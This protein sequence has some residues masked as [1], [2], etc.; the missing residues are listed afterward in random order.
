M[1]D[2]ASWIDQ[3]ER[4][5][6]T[7]VT[8]LPDGDI[9]KFNDSRSKP[10]QGPR[11]GSYTHL[12]HQADGPATVGDY[13]N[14]N[15]FDPGSYT[16]GESAVGGSNAVMAS[17]RYAD[18]DG[19]VGDGMSSGYF[20]PANP[21]AEDWEEGSGDPFMHQVDQDAEQA[22][23]SHML[24]K[25]LGGG[26]GEGAAEGEGAAAAEGP[27]L[28]ELAVLAAFDRGEYSFEDSQG[29]PLRAAHRAGGGPTQ[30]VRV[31]QGV[32]GWQRQAQTYSPPEGFG[33]DGDPELTAYG[34]PSAD[35]G[36]GADVVA[37]FQRSAGALEMM[38][39][40]G[41]APGSLD[42]FGSSPMVQSMLRTAGRK[43]S[44]EEQRMLEAENHPLGAFY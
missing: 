9:I 17:Y 28:A 29:G 2:S 43:Y 26:G 30:Q 38:H 40:S 7:D 20:N 10:Q 15:G 44:P 3:H 34:E 31:D 23:P 11:H 6:F 21:T 35:P 36:M 14:M 19:Y 13:S 22:S 32:R 4:P 16:D 25:G 18:D 33:N 5:D 8:D 42:D 27:E 1:S 24:P 12:L 39:G 37:S 41:P